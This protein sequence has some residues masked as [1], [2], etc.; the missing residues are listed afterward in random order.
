[1]HIYAAINLGTGQE[2]HWCVY[3]WTVWYTITMN[4]VGYIRVSTAEQADSGAGLAAQAEAIRTAVEGRGWR[5]V[6]VCE[7]AGISGKS[8]RR[9]GLERA[10]RMLD[11]GE[12]KAL[13]VAKLD[14]LSRSIVDFVGLMD[15]AQRKG[16]AVVALDLG[17]DT[18]TPQGEVIANVM[19]SFA[20]FERRLIGE[21]TKDALAAKRRQGVKLGRPRSLDDATIRR[22][23]ALREDGMT[24]K[25]IAEYLNE[26]DVPTAQGGA[27]WYPATVRKLCLT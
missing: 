14:R 23:T 2:C 8:V 10:L 3:Q 16:W 17:V 20:Q 9:P 7:D 26:S 15:R 13:L 12:A 4:V 24:Y 19:A 27:Q 6:T 25:A 21:R 1:M 22:I 5:L 18:T 11:R